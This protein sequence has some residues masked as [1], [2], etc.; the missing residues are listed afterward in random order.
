MPMCEDAFGA[1]PVVRLLERAAFSAAEGSV[2]EARKW[3]AKVLEGH[4]R[5]D[6][7]LLLLSETFT[8]AVVHTRSTVIGVVLLGEEDQRLQ[9]EVVSE[10]AETLPCTCRRVSVDAAA[11][12]EWGELAESGRGVRL[13]RAIADQWGYIED[14]PRC[15]V[16]FVLHP[17]PNADQT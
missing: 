15:V 17:H 1:A 9:V 3:A 6:D 10:G 11:P 2:P 8:N 14:R 5:R 7:A 4:P 13:V 12:A 16:W